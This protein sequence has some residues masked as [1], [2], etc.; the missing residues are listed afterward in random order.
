MPELLGSLITDYLILQSELFPGSMTP[1]HNF[2]LHYERIM[3]LM[4]PLSH[5][6]SIR[7]ER[8]HE[9]GKICSR[10]AINRINVCQN[11]N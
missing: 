5:L 9:E 8:K 1:K 4:G 2:L 6:S 7:Y 3:L 11:N 10:V